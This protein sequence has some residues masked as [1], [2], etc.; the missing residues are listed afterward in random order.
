MSP[1]LCLFLLAFDS[2]AE[3]D[4][5]LSIY[6]QNFAVVRQNLTLNLKAGV[7]PVEFNEITSTLEPE[8]VVLR[9]PLGKRVLQ[10]LEQ[11]YQPD[12]VSQAALL[13]KYEGQTIDFSLG[14]SGGPLIRGKIIR[15]GGQ[16]TSVNNGYGYQAVQ[17][18]SPLIEVNGQLQ[19]GLPGTP[20]FPALGPDATLKPTLSWTIQTPNAGPLNAELSYLTK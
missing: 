6:N 20:L 10:I 3:Q 9:D 14:S 16:S 12:P 8:S 18:T 11:N 4:P 15:A 2:P 5:A 1:L 7:T 17:P 13:L 19:F